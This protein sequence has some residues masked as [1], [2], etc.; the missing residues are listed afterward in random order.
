MRTQNC[1]IYV[2]MQ[3]LVQQSRRLPFTMRDKVAK[4]FNRLSGFGI[5]GDVQD[6]TIQVLTNCLFS[7]I[8]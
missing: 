6:A 8:K 7:E 4:K 3:P 5:M 2:K 1:H